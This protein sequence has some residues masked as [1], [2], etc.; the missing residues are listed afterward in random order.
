MI[1]ESPEILSPCLKAPF[2]L[3][4]TSSFELSFTSSFELSFTSPFE[5]SFASPFELSLTFSFESSLFPGSLFQDLHSL[6]HVHHLL[7]IF[8]GQICIDTGI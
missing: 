7:V 5:L 1:H 4:F 6:T 2:E 8:Y 3:P